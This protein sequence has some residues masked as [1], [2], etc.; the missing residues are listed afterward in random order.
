[1]DLP[2]GSLL[3]RKLSLPES[4]L[5]AGADDFIGP[6]AGPAGG[7]TLVYRRPLPATM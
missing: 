5:S 7:L 3:S 4:P 2:K 1:M 6:P